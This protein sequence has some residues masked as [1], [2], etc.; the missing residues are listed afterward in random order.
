[1]NRPL[2]MKESIALLYRRS[3]T[4]NLTV[5]V[6]NNSKTSTT[7]NVT[8]GNYLAQGP[9]CPV[10]F[11]RHTDTH[12]SQLSPELSTVPNWKDSRWKAIWLAWLK[13]FRGARRMS[14]LWCFQHGNWLMG[15]PWTQL[16]F[17][18][19]YS[20]E[21]FCRQNCQPLPLQSMGVIL[22]AWRVSYSHANS[23]IY[24]F[25]L[26]PKLQQ[27]FGTLNQVRLNP[28]LHV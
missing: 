25:I 8:N 13:Q 28:T 20:A 27:V 10:L 6:H 9:S 24:S 23:Q 12:W 3:R 21:Q 16:T 18:C 15:T 5:T 17:T 14:I 1:M 22:E 26:L 11:S 4:Q 7:L 19:R 2:A